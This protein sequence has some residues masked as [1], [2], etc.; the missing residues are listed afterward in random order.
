MNLILIGRKQSQLTEI[1]NEIS[2]KYF[3]KVQALVIDFSTSVLNRQEVEKVLGSKD[4]GIL[5]NNVG[6]ILSHPKFFHEMYEKELLDLIKVNIEAT[7][8]MTMMVLPMMI[9]K[10]KGAII[11]MASTAGLSPQ[12]LQT[13]YAATKVYVDFLSRA[14]QAEYSDYLTFQTICPSYI[15]TSMTSFSSSLDKPSFFVPSPET[16]AAQAMRTLGFSSYTTG[17]W[18]HS[19]QGLLPFGYMPKF[20][21]M[22][23]MKFRQ[24]ALGRI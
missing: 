4:I 18:P 2:S 12:P 5:V 9:Q 10:K 14:L 8:T 23:N 20:I 22:L 6:V 24:E 21:K 17:Y 19:L 13:V 7:T 16:F 1:A 15:C 11:N 3:V